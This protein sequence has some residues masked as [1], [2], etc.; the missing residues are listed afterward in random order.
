M[1]ERIQEYWTLE[2]LF[3]NKEDLSGWEVLQWLRMR[4]PGRGR[5]DL[6]KEVAVIMVAY[7]GWKQ[8]TMFVDEDKIGLREWRRN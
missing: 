6:A 1:E 7:E 2:D 5:G 3:H 4:D 8:G